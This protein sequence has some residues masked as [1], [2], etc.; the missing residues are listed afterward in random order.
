MVDRVASK[1]RAE[2]RGGRRPGAGRKRGSS[3]EVVR[4]ARAKAAKLKTKLPHELLFEWAQTGFMSDKRGQTYAL[5]NS[6][7]I[8]CARACAPWYAAPY[9][10]RPAPGAEP[11]VIRLELDEVTVQALAAKAPDKLEVLRD[12]LKIIATGGGEAGALLDITPA[13][14][15]ADPARY[16]RLIEGA[17]A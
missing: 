5:D 12:V 8:S 10:S 3:P 9:Q 16:G 17:P 15:S 2:R 1:R 7:R 13:R 4:V 11:P 14:A 6:E